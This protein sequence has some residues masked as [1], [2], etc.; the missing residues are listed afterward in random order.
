[1]LKHQGIVSTELIMHVVFCWS[2]QS[3]DTFH[4]LNTIAIK[5][6]NWI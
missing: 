4:W 5:L 2:T 6:K 1:M 3:Y